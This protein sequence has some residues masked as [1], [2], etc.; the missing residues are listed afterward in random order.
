MGCVKKN[1]QPYKYAIKLAPSKGEMI[2]KKFN[3][4]N[5]SRFAVRNFSTLDSK[6]NHT[7]TRARAVGGIDR[8]KEKKEKENGTYHK[9]DT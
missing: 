5:S 6:S 4:L 3:L 1:S 9:T 8:Q 2:E 7:Q